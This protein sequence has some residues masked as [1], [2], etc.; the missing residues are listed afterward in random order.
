VRVKFLQAYLLS[1]GSS[2]RL[3]RGDAMIE[4]EFLDEAT[5]TEG[6]IDGY[7]SICFL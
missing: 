5:E 4:M 2:G 3:A 1:G 7:D 6:V